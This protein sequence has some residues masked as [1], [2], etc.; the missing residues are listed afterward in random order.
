MPAAT[1]AGG[2][3]PWWPAAGGTPHSEGPGSRARPCTPPVRRQP[4]R[5]S[6]TRHRRRPPAHRRAAAE[7]PARVHCSAAG[8]IRVRNMVGQ[9]VNRVPVSVRPTQP[10]TFVSVS[11]HQAPLP[12]V[13]PLPRQR[14]PE[15]DP[16][17]QRYGG[18]EVVATVIRKRDGKALRSIRHSATACQ[19]TASEIKSPPPRTSHQQCRHTDKHGERPRSEQDQ[20]SVER[21]T[22]AGSAGAR[23]RVW[24]KWKLQTR[25]EWVTAPSITRC[26]SNQF[27][28]G[29]AA[30]VVAR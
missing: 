6:P 15:A 9:S 11:D 17:Q 1:E 8:S 14:H 5:R 27:A 4:A 30:V 24:A 25:I 7:A 12:W 19:P 18:P 3:S 20:A 26:S 10:S 22:C 2:E 13:L 21:T 16:Y 28:S 23:S 29:G